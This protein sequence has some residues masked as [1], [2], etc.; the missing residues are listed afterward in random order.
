[1]HARVSQAR[2]VVNLDIALYRGRMSRKDG[3]IAALAEPFAGR[4]YDRHYLAYFDCFNR[5]LF[6]EAHE[7]LEVVWLPQRHA[8]DGDFYKGLIQLAGAF[9]H[10]QKNRLSPAMALF[11]LAETNL[12]KYPAVYHGV[13]RAELNRLI[14][15]CQRILEES[16][17]TSNPLESALAGEVQLSLP[18]R[19]D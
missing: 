7:V 16:K 18:I 12:G 1:M 6:F 8:A 4:D 11:R 14:G 15:R 19:N 9:V 10:L 2:K 3:K 13:N 17:L 5:R